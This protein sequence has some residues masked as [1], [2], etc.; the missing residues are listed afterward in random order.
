MSRPDTPSAIA[1]VE[2]LED[3][4]STPSPR[5]VETMRRIEGDIIVL[6][7]GGKMGPSLTRMAKRASEDAASSRRV[8]AVSRFSSEDARRSLE[9]HGIETLSCDLL[10]PDALEALPDDVPNVIFMAGMKFGSADNQALSWAM[11]AYLPGRVSEK[12]RRSRIVAFSTGNVYGLTPK[13]GGGSRE[14]NPPNPCG[15]YAMSC[16]GRERVFE[17]FSRVRKIPL[18]LIRLNYAAEM[19]YGVLL[20]IARAVWDEDPVPL[21]MGYVNVIWQADANAMSLAALE[22][23][24]TPPYV[25]NVSSHEILSV[26]KVAEEFGRRF[27]RAVRFDG[28]EAPDALLSDGSKGHAEFGLPRVDA[29]RL[30]EWTADWVRRGGPEL[31]KPTHFETR[32]GR[33]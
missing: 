32:N 7:A 20:D 16:V 19:R 2:Q 9:A 33:F 15:E 14:E 27:D 22:C 3:L 13:K 21:T 29:A 4:L 23:T 31:G 30:I 26:R 18:A 12:F 28:K 10:D 11:N 6:G 25:L 24:S 1:S 17:H 5:L 8:I